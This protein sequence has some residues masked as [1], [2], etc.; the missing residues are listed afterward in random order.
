MMGQFSTLIMGDILDTTFDSE[1]DKI[2][3]LT[4]YPWV[5]EKYRNGTR[6]VL[7]I[8]DSHYAVENGIFS[9]EC[10]DDFMST[11]MTTRGIVECHFNN[12]TWNFYRNL[13]GTF[14]DSD[15]L[16]SKIAFYNFIQRPMKQSNAVPEEQ[17]YLVAWRCFA[18]L[19]KVLKPTDCIFIGV[20]SETCCGYS[21]QKMGVECVIK[22]MPILINRTHPRK[23]SIVLSDDYSLDLYFIRHTSQYYSPDQWY[24]FLKQQLPEAMEWLNRK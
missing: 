20:R 8:G 6:R 11:K 12:E 18:D 19:I 17:D 13:E 15:N 9:Q 7:I 3:N 24:E 16:W 5:G 4:W 21:W 10:Y 22:D 1:F 2:E 14:P 23:A